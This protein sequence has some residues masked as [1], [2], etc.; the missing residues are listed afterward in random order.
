MTRHLGF[1]FR[2]AVFHLAMCSAV[3]CAK[4]DIIY[5]VSANTMAIQGTTG[6][7]DLEFNPGGVGTL[8]ATA[9]I[10][11]F[12]TNGTGLTLNAT[13][14]D[15]SGTLSPGPLT[16]SNT[17]GL[18][19]LLENITF[20]TNMTF[21]V[22]LSGPGVTTPDSGLP[23]SSFGLSFYDGSFNPLLTTDP[24]GTV[25]TVNLNP[26]GSISPVTFPSDNSGGV[27]VGGAVPQAPAAVPEPTSIVLFVSG[28]CGFCVY[29]RKSQKTLSR[30]HAIEDGLPAL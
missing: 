9:T 10:A 20:G 30:S 16:I 7:F 26:D 19:D 8:A 6:L 3:V 5:D 18:N 23:G 28:L 21:T 29:V 12:T 11:A 14:G 22:A 25:V 27:A 2:M 24:A 1:C 4:A 13:D 17:F 15:V